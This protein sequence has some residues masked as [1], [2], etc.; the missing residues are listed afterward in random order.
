MVYYFQPKD[1]RSYD[2]LATIKKGE[3]KLDFTFVKAAF[4][5][6]KSRPGIAIATGTGTIIAGSAWAVCKTFKVTRRIDS[7][8]NA[9][10]TTYVADGDYYVDEHVF[11]KKDILKTTAKSYI[12]PAITV[13]AG[14]GMIACG[15]HWMGGIGVVLSAAPATAAIIDKVKEV[16][17]EAKSCASVARED[18]Q[19]NDDGDY[20][21]NTGYGR[22]LFREP[23]TGRL[24]YS[25]KATLRQVT[26]ALDNQFGHD[27]EASLADFFTLMGM[28]MCDVAYDYLWM[29][30]PVNCRHI[31]IHFES[32]E[33]NKTDCPCLNVLFDNEPIRDYVN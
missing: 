11:T 26:T 10:D 33:L 3:V 31:D 19:V 13:A 5:A 6:V 27:G 22:Y 18:N 8:R 32:Y 15:L 2:R 12:G 14:I 16:P 29:Y 1:C 30:D 28:D 7:M 17:E 25:D 20:A 24:F 4:E 21:E 9:V 23:I